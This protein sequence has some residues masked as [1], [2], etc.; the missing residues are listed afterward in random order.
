[1]TDAASPYWQMGL[2]VLNNL[3]GSGA[4]GSDG[5]RVAAL[6]NPPNPI[7]APNPAP[8]PPPVAGQQAVNPPAT[9][10]DGHFEKHW[11]KYALA[12]GALLLLVVGVTFARR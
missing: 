4:F 7:A 3:A 6:I 11:G 2:N 1:M 10:A 9:T 12:G 8:P 5:Q